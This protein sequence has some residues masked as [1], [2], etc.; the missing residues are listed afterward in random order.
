MRYII[1]LVFLVVLGCG[2]GGVG[3]GTA[4]PSCDGV[5]S[6]TG[7]WVKTEDSC[8]NL[9]NFELATSPEVDSCA[10]DPSNNFKWI[11][12]VLTD[13]G[14]FFTAWVTD[15]QKMEIKDSNGDRVCLFTTNGSYT[16]ATGLCFAGF[17]TIFDDPD[18]CT[19][20]YER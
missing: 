14:R 4:D 2:G 5:P 6:V 7:N 8:N 10:P 17:G 1:L 20:T 15:T 12:A 13:D 3:G 11:V 16:I 9:P 19:T 18:L